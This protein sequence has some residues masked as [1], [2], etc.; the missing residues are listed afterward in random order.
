MKD[1]SYKIVKLGSTDTIKIKYNNINIFFKRNLW[2]EIKSNLKKLPYN[3][4]FDDYLKESI[5]IKK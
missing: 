4:Y 3:F 5:E 1:F 2:N